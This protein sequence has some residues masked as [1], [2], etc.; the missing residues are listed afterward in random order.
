MHFNNAQ[1]IRRA[2]FFVFCLAI[3]LVVFGG[4]AQGPWYGIQASFG[5]GG[6]GGSLYHRECSNNLCSYLIGGGVDKCDTNIEC[7]GNGNQNGTTG[8][9]NVNAGTN[10]NMNGGTGGNTNVNGGGTGNTNTNGAGRDYFFKDTANHWVKEY[11]E[12]LNKECGVQGYADQYGNLL[13]QFK[14]DEYITRAE[15]V[16]WGLK[17]KHIAPGTP[18]ADPF[19]DV[20]RNSWYGPYVARAKILGWISGYPDK[21]FRP[22]QFVNRVEATKILVLRNFTW[23]DVIG[24]IMSFIDTL[25]G[26]WYEKY[27]AFA[28]YKGYI[29]G[30]RDAAGNLTGWFGPADNMTRAEAAKIIVNI[31]GF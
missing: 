22:N 8:N 19:P 11:A 7:V 20:S 10:Q 17:C 28:V 26:T 18:T 15:L 24:G 16:V 27:V 3:V 29:E 21:L 12:K 9:G 25:N 31:N 2:I 4:G 30:Y 1:S 6:G 23:Q 13:Y 5:Y 14:P